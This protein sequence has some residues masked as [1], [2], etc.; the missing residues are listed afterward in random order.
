MTK[1][2]VTLTEMLK[3]CLNKDSNRFGMLTLDEVGALDEIVYAT[4]IDTSTRLDFWAAIYDYKYKTYQ[5]DTV[6]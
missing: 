1:A 2:V 4:K 5:D 6:E 3:D